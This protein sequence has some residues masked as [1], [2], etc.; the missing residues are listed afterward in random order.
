M[1]EVIDS[2]GGK[3]EF[4]SNFSNHKVILFGGEYPTSEH[5]FQAM[6]ATTER[7]LEYIRSAPMP[8]QAKWRGHRITICKDW[9]KKRDSAMMLVVFSKFALD[10]DIARELIATG[11]AELI[12]GNYHG[13]DY[14]GKIR[15]GYGGWVGQNKLGEIL[16]S[17]RE[18]LLGAEAFLAA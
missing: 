15:D 1:A 4:L 11:D 13:D 3:Y 18:L 8:A 14:W 2:F 7:D 10:I 12:E 17:V 16:M 6:K 5:A 9:S